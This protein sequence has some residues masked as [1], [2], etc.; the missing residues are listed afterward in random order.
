M[1]LSWLLRAVR[2][3]NTGGSTSGASNSS[4]LTT[5]CALP[6]ASTAAA[7][8]VYVACEATVTLVLAGASR[9][10][11]RRPDWKVLGSPWSTMLGVTPEM[12]NLRLSTDHTTLLI[13]LPT[14]LTDA[15]KVRLQV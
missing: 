10:T 6:A 3:R 5:S 14:S 1:L 9:G 12:L 15:M 13:L 11:A 2:F 8:K 4:F 7:T